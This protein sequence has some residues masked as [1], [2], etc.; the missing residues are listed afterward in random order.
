MCVFMYVCVYVCL[1][2]CMFVC[3]YVSMYIYPPLTTL[4]PIYTIPVY[5]PHSPLKIVPM[6]TGPTTMSDVWEEGYSL[7]ELSKRQVK[8][9]ERKEELEVCHR[10]EHTPI[11]PT[12][13]MSV[14]L[15][16]CI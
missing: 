16:V 7:K 11:K 9:L 8:L 10:K 12:Y 4:Y 1:C 5:T 6:R 14:C 15:Y 3:I 13:S 2:V